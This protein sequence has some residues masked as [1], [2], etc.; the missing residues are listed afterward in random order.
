MEICLKLIWDTNN[1]VS[2]IHQKHEDIRIAD[3]VVDKQNGFGLFP[4]L[5]GKTN[6]VRLF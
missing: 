4:I 5:E 6:H 2:D 1:L 3:I